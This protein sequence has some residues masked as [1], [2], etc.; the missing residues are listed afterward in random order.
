MRHEHQTLKTPVDYIKEDRDAQW[1][2]LEREE[3][4][5]RAKLAEEEEGEGEEGEDDEGE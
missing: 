1:E 4:E 5:R 2:A 3:R